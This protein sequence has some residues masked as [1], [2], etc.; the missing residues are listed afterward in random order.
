MLKVLQNNW[1]DL[2][3]H[4]YCFFSFGAYFHLH[5]LILDLTAFKPV[6]YRRSGSV[7]SVAETVLFHEDVLADR[8]F[9][10]NDS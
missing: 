9:H 8:S 4:R 7:L 3:H 6:H 10:K 2:E 5:E 1:S